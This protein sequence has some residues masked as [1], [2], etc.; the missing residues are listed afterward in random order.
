MIGTPCACR[1]VRIPLGAITV[2]LDDG[3]HARTE[4]N[5]RRAP[6]VLGFAFY[7]LAIAGMCAWVYAMTSHYLAN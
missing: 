4:C 1:A 2:E 3:T 5:V 7:V 6:Q